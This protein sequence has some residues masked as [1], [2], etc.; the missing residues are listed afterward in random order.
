MEDKL[1]LFYYINYSDSLHMDG[2]LNCNIQQPL[3]FFNASLPSSPK[4]GRDQNAFTTSVLLCLGG[5]PVFL[6]KGI[7]LLIS[8][9][10]LIF[11]VSVTVGSLV[12]QI[13]ISHY[14]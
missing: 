12:D 13:I 2:N 7:F 1:Y 5:Y 8:S 14:P 4:K 11:C 6:H 9:L 10:Q 3:N